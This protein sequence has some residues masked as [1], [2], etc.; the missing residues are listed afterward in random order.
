MQTRSILV[1]G[2]RGSGKSTVASG[3]LKANNGI[4]LFDPHFDPAYSWVPNTAR[5]I[6][7]VEDYRRW[8]REAKPERIAVRYVPDGR[9]DPFDALNDFCAWVWTWRNVWICVEEVSESARSPS[10]AGMPPE[11][12]R[13]VNQGRHKGINQIYLGLRYAEIPRPLSAGANVQI[14]FACREPL[15]LDSMRSRIGQEATEKVEGLGQHKALVFFPDRTWRIIRS[16]D[17]GL[18][19]LVLRD[20]AEDVH[21]NVEKEPA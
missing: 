12:R 4:F 10:A 9:V 19:E 3:I 14:L 21:T 5:T 20:A 6:E 7:Q 11:L 1:A 8:R 16:R 15:D 18:A 2:F 17:P 13:I